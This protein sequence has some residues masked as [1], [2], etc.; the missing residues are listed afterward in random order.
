MK[1][2]D[3]ISIIVMAVFMVPFFSSCDPPRRCNEPNCLYTDV[4]VVL[5]V[6]LSGN[7][8]SIINAGDT[9][10]V[11][12]KL[13][14][15]LKTNGYG[16]LQIQSILDM[17]NFSVRTGGGDSSLGGILWITKEYPY[18]PINIAPIYLQQDENKNFNGSFN[19]I[20][21][22]FECLFV[23]EKSG[24]YILEVTYGRLDFKDINGKEWS[25]NLQFEMPEDKRRYNQYLNWLAPDFQL[26]ANQLLHSNKEIYWFEV[27]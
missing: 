26:E 5:P 14:D 11:L 24:K 13:P 27:Q 2:R 7:T 21:Q 25:V 15:I 18:V 20:T 23:P 3:I 8:D 10:R 4:N 16:D 6:V 17:N 19:R 12:V 22:T 9:L 1:I